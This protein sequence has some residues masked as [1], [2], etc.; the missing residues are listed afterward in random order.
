MLKNLWNNFKA[1]SDVWF[2]YGFLATFT[3]SIRKVIKFYPIMGQFNEYSGIYLY[4]SDIFLILTIIA[5]CIIVLFKLYNTK[6]TLSSII[7]TNAFNKP[8]FKILALFN[9]WVF[10]SIFWADNQ[11]IALFR[12]IKILEFSLLFLYVAF[13]IVPRGTIDEVYQPRLNPESNL[14]S[15]AETKM[16]NLNVPRGTLLRHIFQIFISLGLFQ[17]IIGIWQFFVQHSV[18]LLWLKESLISPNI[19]GVA[20]VILNGEKYIRAYGLFPHPN[21]LGGF[22]LFSIV[23]TWMYSKLF[24]LGKIV[25]RGTIRLLSPF[26]KGRVG[27]G[28]LRIFLGIQLLA[29]LLTFSKSA[30]FGLIFAG[31]YITH[32]IVPRGTISLKKLFHPSQNVPPRYK[33]STWNNIGRAEH[34]TRRIMLIIGIIFVLGFITKTDINS[35][36]FKTLNER[37]PQLNIAFG[38]IS[39]HPLLGVGIGQFV[40]DMN[41]NIPPQYKCS[42]WN[43]LRG[44]R[45]PRIDESLRVEAGG[46]FSESWQYQPAHNVF[47]LIWSELGIAGL[48]LFILFIHKVLKLSTPAKPYMLTNIFKSVI[49]G[50][51][52]ISLFDHY[53]WDIQQ[54]QIMLWLVA[55]LALGVANYRNI[56]P[57]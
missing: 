21:I 6:C 8:L 36:F 13:R 46:I 16:A 24:Y 34:S 32:N 52:F 10:I 55:S 49:I 22:L 35:L 42:T 1:Q 41:K 40:S 14:D 7:P 51:L 4:L 47:L 15:S 12:A 28:F 53:L 29:L 5:F 31:L 2:F 48:I 38:T 50:F 33:C 17:A 18:G 26:Y 11:A 54:G 3:L 23:I 25:P 56:D 39:D 37:L 45:A 9:L 57:V 30:I 43:I 20:K 27:E 44:G 19:N